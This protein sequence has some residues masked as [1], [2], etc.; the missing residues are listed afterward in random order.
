MRFMKAC[1]RRT[2]VPH[3]STA[4]A[5]HTTQICA[6]YVLEGAQPCPRGAR[7][8]T[9]FRLRKT[10][11]FTTFCFESS[12]GVFMKVVD[13]DVSFQFSLVWPYLDIHNLSYY[14]NTMHGSTRSF[15][16]PRLREKYEYKIIVVTM[17]F[18]LKLYIPNNVTLHQRGR[19]S[20]G[21]RQPSYL[22]KLI[23]LFSVMYNRRIAPNLSMS[24][25]LL[26]CV[27]TKQA[28]SWGLTAIDLLA[29][30]ASTIVSIMSSKT[31]FKASP[32][33]PCISDISISKELCRSTEF[34]T[35]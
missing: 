1:H 8:C 12:L 33:I 32:S 29:S 3:G 35:S 34:S 16:L 20:V 9:L 21:E 28:S 19:S 22:R 5:H 31:S 4:R 27:D 7:S 30:T 23:K 10:S 24:K 26:W 17:R 14:Q 25:W 11:F 18:F 2:V 15:T 13:M 6:L